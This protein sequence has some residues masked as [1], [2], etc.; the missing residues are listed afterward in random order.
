MSLP[1]VIINQVHKMGTE[2]RRSFLQRMSLGVSSVGAMSVLPSFSPNTLTAGI[3]GKKLNIALC[4]L[5]RYAGYL[6]EGIAVSEY[7]EVAGII[8]GTP[9]K[10]EVWKKKYNIPDANI[11]DYKELR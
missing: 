9:A 11:Y 2:S 10:A 7:C 4:G 6:A 3:A 8:T 1:I 5:G